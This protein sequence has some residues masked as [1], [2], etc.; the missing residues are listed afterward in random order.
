MSHKY[1]V[2]SLTYRLEPCESV[3]FVNCPPLEFV[4]GLGTFRFADGVLVVSLKEKLFDSLETAKRA[5]EAVLAAWDAKTRLDN[6]HS[7]LT[8]RYS[9][10][11]VTP[12]TPPRG[13][14][15][16]FAEGVS[17]VAFVGA[18]TLTLTRSTYPEPPSDFQMDRD[19]ATL[20]ARYEQHASGR[21]PLQS[22]AYFV[23]TV[24]EGCNDGRQYFGASN[25]VRKTLRILSSRKG[26]PL[27]ARKAD[28]NTPLT[29]Q[30]EEWL[31]ATVR[32]LIRR[33][34]QFAA[35]IQL[36]PLNM[37]DLPPLS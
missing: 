2:T 36:K 17:S 6:W 33:A 5:V 7:A 32:E 13:G 25:G 23:A 29:P 28:A 3:K 21:E 12:K 34:G 22:M 11:N 27:T 1:W 9:S 15:V 4:N 30:E 10:S 20:W 35:G 26:D 24:L 16:L 31:R 14:D 37:N 8:F 18:A 19:V